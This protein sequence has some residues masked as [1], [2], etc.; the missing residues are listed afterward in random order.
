MDVPSGAADKLSLAL[1]S[2]CNLIFKGCRLWVKGSRCED[3]SSTTGVPQIA[4]DLL[5]RPS[6]QSRAKSG[7]GN[8]IGTTFGFDGSSEYHRYHSYVGP[9]S[10]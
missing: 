3:V 1:P 9:R 8:A 10:R 2:A 6:R 5:Q 4:A 7:R